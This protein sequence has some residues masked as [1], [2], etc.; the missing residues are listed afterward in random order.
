M[1]CWSHCPCISFCHQQPDRC[2]T[3]YRW[4]EL[5][6]QTKPKQHFL[7]LVRTLIF[8]SRFLGQNKVLSATNT[9]DIP[10]N[11][12]KWPSQ[13]RFALQGRADCGRIF[14]NNVQT[15]QIF[16]WCFYCHQA[17]KNDFFCSGNLNLFWDQETEVCSTFQVLIIDQRIWLKLSLLSVESNVK[18]WAKQKHLTLI[19]S[20]KQIQLFS[21]SL[22]RIDHAGS[23]KDADIEDI[24]GPKGPSH[25]R[26]K[27][28]WDLYFDHKMKLGGKIGSYPTVL[29]YWIL[30]DPPLNKSTGTSI[31][32]DATL[33]RGKTL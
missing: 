16:I 32:G 33:K 31:S 2:I 28:R 1:H 27:M 25:S 4:H 23:Q 22:L 9:K 19:R 10:S 24:F 3:K 21:C 29:R 17:I 8:H 6:K 14:L 18:N 13:G 26:P 7:E 15:T 12:D 20:E 5:T 30:W 11:R